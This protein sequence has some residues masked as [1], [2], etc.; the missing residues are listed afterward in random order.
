MKVTFR[1]TSLTPES[2]AQD[3]M[4]PDLRVVN[5]DQQPRVSETVE[6]GGEEYDVVAVTWRYPFT[7]ACEAVVYVIAHR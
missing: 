2:E 3:I 1:T 5:V 6:L 4:R 7:H